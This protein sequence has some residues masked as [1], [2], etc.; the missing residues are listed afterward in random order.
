M[1]R[2]LLHVPILA[3]TGWQP[4]PAA[5]ACAVGSITGISFTAHACPIHPFVS[6]APKLVTRARGR[7]GELQRRTSFFA[8]AIPA[9]MTG[10]G[11]LNYDVQ[12]AGAAAS[13]LSTGGNPLTSQPIPIAGPGIPGRQPYRSACRLGR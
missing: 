5:A 2:C 10:A 8:P 4:E 9:R 13:L 1:L 7:V 3:S 12:V 6:F 11:V